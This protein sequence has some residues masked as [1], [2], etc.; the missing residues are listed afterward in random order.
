MAYILNSKLE[1]GI[2]SRTILIVVKPD[3][4]QIPHVFKNLCSGALYIVQ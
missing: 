4:E 3:S 2:E 1:I